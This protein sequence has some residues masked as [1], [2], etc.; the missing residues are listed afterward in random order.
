MHGAC[1][2]RAYDFMDS[3][4]QVC[5]AFW[6]NVGVSRSHMHLTMVPVLI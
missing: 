6:D 5:R 2:F 1:G 4:A 3:A